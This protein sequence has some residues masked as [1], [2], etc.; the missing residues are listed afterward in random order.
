MASILDGDIADVVADALTSAGVPL[1][2]TLRRTTTVDP[3]TPWDPSDDVVTTTDYPC[4][5]WPD[6]F[7]ADWIAGGLVQATDARVM[8]IPSTLAV[9]PQPGDRVIV[10]DSTLTVVAVRS[11]PALALW[12]LQARA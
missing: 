1:D 12:D 6:Q 4:S 10:R 5:G 8:I 2:L 7:A 3:G 11:D 9:E